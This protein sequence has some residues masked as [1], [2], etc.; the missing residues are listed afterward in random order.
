[1]DGFDPLTSGVPSRSRVD[2][3]DE[4]EAEAAAAARPPQPPLVTLSPAAR[5]ACVGDKLTPPL[6]VR[7]A[8]ASRAAALCA[9]HQRCSERLTLLAAAAAAV[10]LPRQVLGF[11]P[12][13]SALLHHLPGAEVRRWRRCARVAAAV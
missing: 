2:E 5:A 9:T 12:V 7:R 1:M 6:L 3:D 13:A 8:C 10:A 4:A 11:G